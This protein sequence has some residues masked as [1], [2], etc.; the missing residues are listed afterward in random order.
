MNNTA[1]MKETETG[2]KQST[3]WDSIQ[4]KSGFVR[5]EPENNNTVR[6]RFVTGEPEEGVNKFGN[7]VYDFEVVEDGHIKILQVSSMRLMLALK[8]K[9]PLEG[10]EVCIQRIGE[11]FKTTYNVELIHRGE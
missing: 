5:F 4:E 2:Q 9:V 1:A 10:V 8:E 3:I 7:T 6:V 11:G